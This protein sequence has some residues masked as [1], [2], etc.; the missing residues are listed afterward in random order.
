ATCM[1][2]VIG[3]SAPPCAAQQQTW[4]DVSGRSMTAE[5]V[6]L[7]G[8]N[9]IFRKDGKEV[10][11]PI[12]RL[13]PDAR[14]RA[15]QLAAERPAAQANDA[16][17]PFATG[18]RPARASGERANKALAAEDDRDEDADGDRRTG[19]SRSERRKWTDDKGQQVT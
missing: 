9:V 7:D 12:T 19:S 15:V 3:T 17:D 18:G 11:V 16:N 6:R 5:F 14:D 10:A 1:V 4:T 13:S 8:T 2:A